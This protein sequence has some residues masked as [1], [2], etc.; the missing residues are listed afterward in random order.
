MAYFA[1]FSFRSYLVVTCFGCAKCAC[2]KEPPPEAGGGVGVG[3]R[4]YKIVSLQIL[5]VIQINRHIFCVLLYRISSTQM[6]N[7]TRQLA[8]PVLHINIKLFILKI[9]FESNN[10]SE[11]SEP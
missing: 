1:T 4:F 2:I 6:K 11:L 7:T 3:G 5:H 10:F 9:I 8:Q